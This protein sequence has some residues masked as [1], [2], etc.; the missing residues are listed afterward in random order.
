MDLFRIY[1]G[2]SQL[3]GDCDDSNPEISPIAIETCDGIDNDC[4]GEM[5]E[6]VL[7]TFYADEDEDGYGNPDQ[8]QDACEVPEGMVENSDDCN[9]LETLSHP[10]FFE[11]CA[12]AQNSHDK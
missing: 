12:V 11:I 4:D 3:D 5:D 8:S 7:L 1:F 2:L 9:D 6:G 10:N